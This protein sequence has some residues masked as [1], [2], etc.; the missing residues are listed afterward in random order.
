M[1]SM[2]AWNGSTQTTEINKY[3]VSKEVGAL[4]FCKQTAVE[5]L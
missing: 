5:S 4:E 1:V 3:R 2:F